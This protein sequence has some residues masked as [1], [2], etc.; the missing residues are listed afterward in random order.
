MY[1]QMP[2]HDCLP[3]WVPGTSNFVRCPTCGLTQRYRP[4]LDG[5]T[6]RCNGYKR[7]AHFV[8]RSD[9]TSY[10]NSRGK[11]KHLCID[12][13]IAFY[14]NHPKLFPPAISSAEADAYFSALPTLDDELSL[15]IWENEGGRVESI[16][17]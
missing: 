9:I 17:T 16:D 11:Y 15:A 10:I 3:E 8:F 6:Y 13:D 12:C 2:R 7:I 14:A 1:T 5:Y 4:L